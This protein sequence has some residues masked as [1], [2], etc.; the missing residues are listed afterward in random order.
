[1]LKWH[2]RDLPVAQLAAAARSVE[3]LR[4]RGWPTPRWLANG[5]LPE[6]TA[7]IIED[8]VVGVVPAQIDGDGLDQLLIANRL[9]ANVRPDTEH[10]WSSYIHRVV[11]DGEAGLVDRMRARPV[12][13]ALLSRLERLTEGARALRLPTTD[14][15]HGDFVLR[16]MLVAEGSLR[17]ID[18]AH[19]GKGTRAYDLAALLLETTVEGGWAE[20]TIDPARVEAECLS[21]VGPAGLRVCLAGRMLHYI[22]FGDAWRDYDP[23]SLVANCGAFIER[24][25]R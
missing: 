23:S 17:I 11:F 20:P 25:E 24:Y 10:D 19:V 5:T 13:A 2:P 15:V 3:E 8:F 6:G 7:Y 22:V 9:Q 14:F 4:A 12:T 16:N 18:T 1:M 21:I